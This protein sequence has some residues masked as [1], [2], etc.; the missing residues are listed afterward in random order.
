MRAPLKIVSF[1][2]MAVY[3]TPAGCEKDKEEEATDDSATGSVVSGG[4]GADDGAAGDGSDT[5]APTPGEGP[6]FSAVSS[7]GYS[8]MWSPA[9]DDV[10]SAEVLEY[11]LVTAPTTAELE[12]VEAALAVAEANVL[13]AWTVAGSSFDVSGLEAES[14]A[15]YAVLVRDEAGNVGLYAPQSVTTLEYGAP[16]PGGDLTIS[17]V[18]RTGFDVAWTA[19]TDPSGLELTYKVVYAGTASD[20]DTVAEADAITGTTSDWLPSSS[21]SFAISGLSS[22]MSY[23]VAVLVK[24]SAA[25]EALYTP[26]TQLTSPRRIFVTAASFAG[27]IRT[28]TSPDALCGADGDNPGGSYKGLVSYSTRYPCSSSLCQTGGASENTNWPIAPGVTY[29]RPDGTVIGK[30]NSIGMFDGSL[31]NSISDGPATAAWFGLDPATYINSFNCAAWTW[32]D[33]GH[34]S[35]LMKLDQTDTAQVFASGT[36][37]TCNST[38][39]LVCVEQ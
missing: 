9:T 29:G 39:P 6:T 20:I 18:T 37:T 27:H 16:T 13:L 33:V 17:A 34:T 38:M 3:L 5:T 25:L 23:A 12:T 7:S 36:T 21:T 22:G 31:T 11:Q 30:A 28:Y 8:V 19:A 35:Y 26:A 10:T 24:N 15:A 1:L 32:N 4:G 2:A 14:S